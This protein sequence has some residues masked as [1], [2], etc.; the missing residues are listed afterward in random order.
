MKYELNS[1]AFQGMFALPNCVAEQHIKLASHSALKVII[2]I[3]KNGTATDEAEFCKQL[4]ISAIELNEALLYWRSAGLLNCESER[5]ATE[6][7]PDGKV[8]SQVVARQKRVTRVEVA[9][10]ADESR[11]IALVLQ[12]AEIKFARPLKESEK[13]SL[14]YILDDLGMNPEITL[15]LLEHA[16]TEGRTTSSFLESTAV[17][18]INRSIDTVAL[19]EKEMTK[20]ELSKQAWA[21]VR[22]AA[23]IDSRRPSAKEAEFSLRWVGEWGFEEKMLRLAY[24]QCVDAIGKLS[25]P[26]MDKILKG[27][28]TSGVATPDAAA[29]AD[30]KRQENKKDNA[31]SFDLSL[32]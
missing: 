14:V 23:S 7:K 15:M 18:W 5:Q 2:Y 11:D 13:S 16:A 32:F 4:G 22:R 10:R 8:K 24:D 1:V 3:M 31:P 25:L 30:Q 26:Y 6:S 29:A 20:A 21:V 9:R 19:A 28:H 17:D 12:Q 27:W